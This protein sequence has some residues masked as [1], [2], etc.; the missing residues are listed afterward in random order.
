LAILKQIAKV[1]IPQIPGRFPVTGVQRSFEDLS[2]MLFAEIKGV[3]PF[4]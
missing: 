1:K 3:S 4:L 2:V